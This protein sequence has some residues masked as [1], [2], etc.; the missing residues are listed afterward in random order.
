MDLKPFLRQTA[1]Y[2]Q[3]NGIDAEGNRAYAP[4]VTIPCRKVAKHKLMRTANTESYISVTEVITNYTVELGGT[5]DGEELLAIEAI[6]DFTGLTLG[7][8]CH[9]RPPVGFAN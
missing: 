5:L 3:P 8:R 1:I 6:V 2:R 4:A 9:P 7:Y